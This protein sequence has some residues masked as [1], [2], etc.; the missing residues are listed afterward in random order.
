M[1]ARNKQD[2]QGMKLTG[3]AN[4]SSDQPDTSMSMRDVTAHN[5]TQNQSADG[6]TLEVFGWKGR[7]LWAVVALAIIALAAVA[8]RLLL[9]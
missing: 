2:M 3:D 6:P 7:G 9:K 8:A 4:Q 5:A 1:A